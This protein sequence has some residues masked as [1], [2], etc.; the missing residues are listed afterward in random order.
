MEPFSIQK[1]QEWEAI[2][3]AII[4]KDYSSTYNFLRVYDDRLYL[5]NPGNLPEEFDN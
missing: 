5:W 4:H 2:L 3:N 1:W